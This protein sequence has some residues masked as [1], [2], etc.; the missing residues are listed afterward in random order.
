MWP[1]AFSFQI[2][3]AQDQGDDDY[4]VIF[5][6][7]YGPNVDIDAILATSKNPMHEEVYAL[8]GLSEDQMGMHTYQFSSQLGGWELHQ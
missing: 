8:L 6:I 1:H 2:M 3:L 7:V 5:P 4:R